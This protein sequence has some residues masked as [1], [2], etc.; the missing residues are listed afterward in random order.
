[1]DCNISVLYCWFS[2]GQ[3]IIT[4]K[5]FEFCS[6][7]GV[8]EESVYV[9]MKNVGRVEDIITIFTTNGQ[10]TNVK[11]NQ[12]RKYMRDWDQCWPEYL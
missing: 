6:D 9:N 4:K 1:M 10:I 11:R 12:S 8:E 2:R 7:R 3:Y 5:Y